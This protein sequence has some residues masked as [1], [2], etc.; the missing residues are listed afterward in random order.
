MSRP[1]PS[2]T[3]SRD[4]TGFEATGREEMQAVTNVNELPALELRRMI[5]QRE[6]S[7]PEL[8]GEFLRAILAIDPKIRSYVTIDFDMTLNM[9]EDVERRLAS[10]ENL[11]LAGIPYALKDLTDT[12]GLRTTYGSRARKDNVPE[13]DAAVARRL[14]AAGGTLL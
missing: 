10:G 6:I 14:K 4:G 12:A 11:P 1:R 5:L 8:A 2:P 13:A 7:P 3:W 9:A